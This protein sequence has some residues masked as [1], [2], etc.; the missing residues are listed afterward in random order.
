MRY[1]WLSI[2]ILCVGGAHAQ[3]PYPS[4]ERFVNEVF[5]KVID[6]SLSHYFLIAGTDTCRFV[7]FD[8]DEWA[9]YHTSE[10]VPI[11]ILNELAGKV[12][13][14]HDP[15]FWKQD[16]LLQAICIT[17]RT[18]DSILYLNPPE[19]DGNRSHYIYSFSLPQF[20]DDGKYA[21][22]DLNLVCGGRCGV[23]ATYIFRRYPSGWKPVGKYQNW[24]APAHQHDRSN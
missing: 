18:A 11:S 20:T 16:S 24:Q 12:Y 17:R 15:Y 1:A 4:P 7:K 9:D 5:P 22:I 10:P 19:G 8:Y 14:S 2:M 13:G 6:S 21:V 23:G 3:W